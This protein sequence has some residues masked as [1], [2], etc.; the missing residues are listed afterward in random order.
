MVLKSQGWR[1]NKKGFEE[2]FLPL[3]DTCNDPN[4]KTGSK[5]RDEIYCDVMSSVMSSLYKTYF[6]APVAP[7]GPAPPTPRCW[8]CPSWTV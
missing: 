6:Q 2:V 7:R 5:K 1:Y 4:G 8:S 3:S